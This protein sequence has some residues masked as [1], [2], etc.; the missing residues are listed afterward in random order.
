MMGGEA[1]YLEK[2]KINKIVDF[3]LARILELLAG[4]KEDVLDF[5]S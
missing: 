4:V 1:S 3:S 5:Q 2:N